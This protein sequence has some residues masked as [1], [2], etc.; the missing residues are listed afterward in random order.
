VIQHMP[1][2]HNALSSNPSTAPSNR[3]KDINLN[4]YYS[5]II[6]IYT[7]LSDSLCNLGQVF[8]PS[9]K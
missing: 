7:P 5:N 1:S 9:I 2:N 8:S 3:F 4:V 6:Y